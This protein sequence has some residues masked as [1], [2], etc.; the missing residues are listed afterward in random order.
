MLFLKKKNLVLTVLGLS[1]HMKF[2]VD[3]VSLGC[4]LVAAAWAL[5]RKASVVA[6][7]GL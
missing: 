1:S 4:C 5:R 6:A 3:A 2:S 7:P